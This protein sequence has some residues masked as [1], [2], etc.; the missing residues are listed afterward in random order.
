MYIAFK[1]KENSRGLL[2]VLD[3]DV[4]GVAVVLVVPGPGVA[5]GGPQAALGTLANRRTPD[6]K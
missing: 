1:G 5:E 3:A 2:I 4:A 6:T